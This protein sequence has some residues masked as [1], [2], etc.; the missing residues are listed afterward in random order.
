MVFLRPTERAPGLL[1]STFVHTFGDFF[2]KRSSTQC[3]QNNIGKRAQSSDKEIFSFETLQKA[4]ESSGSATANNHIKHM[5]GMDSAPSTT[6]PQMPTSFK[7]L[8]DLEGEMLRTPAAP[9]H[10]VP[11]E[12]HANAGI[13]LCF[14]FMQCYAMSKFPLSSAWV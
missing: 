8:A 12:S 14:L 3:V 2:L 13:D 11:T 9:R 7:T 4:A 6:M 1:T 10:P 5:L